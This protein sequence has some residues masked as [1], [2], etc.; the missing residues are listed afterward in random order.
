MRKTLLVLPGY[1]VGVGGLLLI[2]Y[3]TLLAVGSEGKAINVQVNRF[4]EQYLDLAC[5]LFL[6]VVCL[7]GLW[8]L[9]SVVHEKKSNDAVIEKKPHKSTKSLHSSYEFSHSFP[10][11]PQQVVKGKT[12]VTLSSTDQG[13]LIMQDA[14]CVGVF[15][16]LVTVPQENSKEEK[17]FLE[18]NINTDKSTAL[19]SHSVE[20]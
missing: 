16:V 12:Q 3:R 20:R 7:V 11:Q 4:G 13:I 8:S 2:T 6:W 5:L 1:C 14:G 9:S 18:K 15:S 19:S 10:T 17:K